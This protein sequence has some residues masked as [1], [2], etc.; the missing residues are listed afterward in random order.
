MKLTISLP[1]L[2][3]NR[4]SSPHFRTSLRGCLP[5]PP[6]GTY[7][8]SLST[9]S[10]GPLSHL[11]PH[12]YPQRMESFKALEKEIKTKAFS[13][14]G[15]I[16]ATRLDPAEQAKAEARNTLELYVDSLNRQIEQTEAE[17]ELIQAATSGS[18]KKKSKSGAGSSGEKE[19]ELERQNE[20]S[21]WHVGK[22]EAVMRM[23]ENGK[24][25][26]DQVN[27]LKEDVSYFVESN[28]VS[29]DPHN[30]SAFCNKGKK[31]NR[32]KAQLR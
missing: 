21:S 11:I 14:E 27:D 15:L 23:L 26:P 4:T 31:K 25:T 1:F 19:K 24:V 17:I 30:L 7:S 32:P 29:V 28:Q 20:R 18:S 6:Y 16:A 3:L 9:S 10:L 8:L 12:S 2:T 13:K 22:L 5:S